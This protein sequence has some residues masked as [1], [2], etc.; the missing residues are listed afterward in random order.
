MENMVRAITTN[1][2]VLAAMLVVVVLSAALMLSCSDGHIP[3]VGPIGVACSAMS[4][5]FGSA[6]G[7]AGS[8]ILAMFGMTVAML[9]VERPWSLR[10]CF[11][12][13]KTQRNDTRRSYVERSMRL[14]L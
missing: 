2:T 10:S 5:S 8:I 13:L 1:R 11:I 9:H 4:H 12:A 7:L 6:P 3:P 14:R